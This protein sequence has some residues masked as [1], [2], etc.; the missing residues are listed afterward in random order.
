[1]NNIES[2]LLNMESTDS[3]M[4]KNMVW[5]SIKLHLAGNRYDA[6]ERCCE[7]PMSLPFPT[8]AD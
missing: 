6:A 8:Y 3:L 4:R 1:M 7:V 5:T 2:L